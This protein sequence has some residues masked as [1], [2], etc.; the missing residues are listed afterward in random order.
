M[1]AKNYEE[2]ELLLEMIDKIQLKDRMEVA[3]V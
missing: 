1:Y 3:L 2:E